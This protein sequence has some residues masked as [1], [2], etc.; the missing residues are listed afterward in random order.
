MYSFYELYGYYR[1]T[2]FNTSLTEVKQIRQERLLYFQIGVFLTPIIFLQY[3]YRNFY[4]Q[5]SSSFLI[6]QYLPTRRVNVSLRN[7]VNI[8]DTVVKYETLHGSLLDF[9]KISSFYVSF[10]KLFNF[11]CEI[12]FTVRGVNVFL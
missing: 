6:I 8:R 7:P 1:C 12:T 10:I 11:T 2:S 3:G 4:S 9:M 5:I